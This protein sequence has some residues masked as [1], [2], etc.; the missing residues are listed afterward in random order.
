MCCSVSAKYI[1][2]VRARCLSISVKCLYSTS[3][4]DVWCCTLD[5]D[6][7]SDWEQGR[8]W[9]AAGYGGERRLY[10]PVMHDFLALW[11]A[12]TASP[13]NIS[14]RSALAIKLVGF[15]VMVERYFPL[16][17]TAEGVYYCRT[18]AERAAFNLPRPV[19]EKFSVGTERVGEGAFLFFFRAQMD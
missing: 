18:K 12:R 17:S 10:P 8:L 11:L 7:Q 5:R 3:L 2:F 19:T 4:T 13:N 14:S 1:T 9:A 16:C 6:L 15:Q